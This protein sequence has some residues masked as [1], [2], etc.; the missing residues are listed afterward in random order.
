MPKHGVSRETQER[1]TKYA[2]R[3][4]DWNQRINLVSPA[5]LTSL[6]DR[7]IA[8]CAQIAPLAPAHAQWLDIGSGGGLPGIVVAIML[9][10]HQAGHVHLVESNRKKASF[11]LSVTTELRLP[12]TVHACRIEQLHGKLANIDIVTARAVAA[13]PEL[14]VM[15][16]PW[17]TTGAIGLFQKGRDYRS[18]LEHCRDEWSFTLVEHESR[19]DSTAVILEMRDP[20]RN[21]V[22]RQSG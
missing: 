18:E 5:D 20:V 14:L 9:A 21:P 7:H 10:E 2:E 22:G 4:T 6:W 12:A 16:E 1:L 8:D 3:L 11:L 13:L 17:L 19:T 15:A